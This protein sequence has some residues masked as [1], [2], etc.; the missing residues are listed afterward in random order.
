M[1]RKHFKNHFKWKNFSYQ[2]HW[3]FIL[4]YFILFY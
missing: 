4:F 1:F 2:I 3:A